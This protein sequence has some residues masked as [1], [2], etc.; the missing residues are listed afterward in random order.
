MPDAEV[1]RAPIVLASQNVLQWGRSRADAEL[2]SLNPR[3]TG[4]ESY[5]R[6]AKVSIAGV[7]IVIS[8]NNRSEIRIHLF[9]SA[10]LHSCVN[11]CVWHLTSSRTRMKANG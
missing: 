1:N 3:L 9:L 5:L 11:L 6:D 8:V 10:N 2:A 7:Y 4:K